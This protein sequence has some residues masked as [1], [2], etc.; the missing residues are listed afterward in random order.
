[1]VTPVRTGL[2]TDVG[3]LAWLR[4]LLAPDPDSAP[5]PDGTPVERYR[6]LPSG[7]HPRVVVPLGHPAAAR[8]VLRS[9]LGNH[10][11]ARRVTGTLSRVGSLPRGVGAPLTVAAGGSLAGWLAE[12]LDRPDLHVGIT[13]GA[14]RPN[15]KPV[16]KLVASDGTVVAFA[17]VAWNPLTTALVANEQRWLERI[18][19]ERPVGITAPQPWLA[20]TWKGMP[21]LITR[22]LAE[23]EAS[24]PFRVDGDLVAAIADLAPGG[25]HDL[26]DS[27]WW[28]AAGERVDALD[29]EVAAGRLAA[30]RS[31]LASRLA[32]TRWRF[33]AWHGDLTAWNAHPDPAGV[34]VWDWERASDPVPVGF[35]AAHAAFQAGQ[36]G[37]GLDVD[38]AAAEAGPVVAEVVDTIGLPPAPADDLVTCY[39]VER[40]LRWYED[41]AVGST[42][43]TPDRQHA[44]QHAITA[45]TTATARR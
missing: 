27:P 9:D 16:L 35:D 31:V 37:R 11:L 44:I 22:P 34:T 19:A 38:T 1:V 7:R 25:E 4:W 24:V 45:R 36:V 40:C 6:V 8:A 42:T 15:R 39:L 17:K 5:P 3:A 28:K 2:A 14:P 20:D 10:G 33:G 30:A 13:V 32:G 23:P 26:V 43:A 12:R 41:R 18:D 21:V 29:D